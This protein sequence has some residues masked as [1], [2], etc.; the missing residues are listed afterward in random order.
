MS[1][2]E[3]LL[4]YELDKKSGWIAALL[5][6][7]LPGLGYGYCGRWAIGIFAFFL[8]LAMIKVMGEAA[9][10]IVLLLFIDGFL[11]AGR[12]NKKVLEGLIGKR[13]APKSEMRLDNA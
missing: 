4:K 7:F 1:D 13:D 8:T 3:L 5:N 9:I 11:A 12:H 10:G 6:L 2:T